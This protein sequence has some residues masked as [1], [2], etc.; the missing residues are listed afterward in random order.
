GGGQA[1]AVAVV[2]RGP[3]KTGGD[4]VEVTHN[5][6]TTTFGNVVGVAVETGQ[7][8]DTVSFTGTWSAV[9]DVRIDL[10]NGDDT[11]TLEKNAFAKSLQLM[12][13]AG[14]GNDTVSLL[15]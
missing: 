2:G 6:T 3:D 10:G 5:G 14:G 8:D 7:G 13:D 1:E 9:G 4:A 12:I 15:S 11:A